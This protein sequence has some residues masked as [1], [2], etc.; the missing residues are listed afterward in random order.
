MS[1]IKE[2]E[3]VQ[4]ESS[5]DIDEDGLLDA[6]DN[7]ETLAGY[8]EQRLEQLKRE[9]E[10]VRDLR[11]IDHG[12]YT[13]VDDEKEVIR[14]S[15]NEK[16]CVIHF[17]HRNF[18]RCAI[19]HKHLEA[20]A[21]RYFDTRFLRVF[22]EAVPW[23]VERLSIKVLPCVIVFIDGVTKD[24]IVGFEQLGNVDDFPTSALEMRLR[25]SGAISNSPSSSSNLAARL[26][27]SSRE[28]DAESDDEESQGPKRKIRSSN[29]Q[30]DDD[31]DL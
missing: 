17:Y 20:I 6:L 26:G 30:S 3:N 14:I 16:R 21:P 31:Y 25:V 24:R 27:I 18:Q 28:N 9:A 5:S 2:T 7:D 22:V 11:E 15:A 1:S 29:R 13:E 10:H 12:K 19:M 4:T 23:L 8:R